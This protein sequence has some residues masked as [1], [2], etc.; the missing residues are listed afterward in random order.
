MEEDDCQLIRFYNTGEPVSENDF[1]H[2]FESF[3]RAANSQG[4]PGN[5]LGLYI[6]REIMRKMDGAIY[7]ERTEE[8]MAF[9]LVFE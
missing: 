7:A 8:G 3:Y 6:C 1:N 9:V 4:Q 2:I 5:G